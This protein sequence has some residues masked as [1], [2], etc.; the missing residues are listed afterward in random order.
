MNTYYSYRSYHLAGKLYGTLGCALAWGI[1]GFGWWIFPL[2]AVLLCLWLPVILR[3]PYFLTIT[4][5]SIQWGNSL[6]R[7]DIPWEL[8]ESIG[9]TPDYENHPALRIELKDGAL[10]DVDP[11]CFNSLPAVREAISHASGNSPLHLAPDLFASP[12]LLSE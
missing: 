12:G 8:I 1:F 9:C 5:V 3:K 6:V 11:A 7:R 10:L 4:S 2:G